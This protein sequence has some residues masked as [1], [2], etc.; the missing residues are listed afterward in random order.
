MLNQPIFAPILRAASQLSD[1]PFVGVLWRSVAW[2]TVC[3]AALHV[4]AVWAVH[5][6]LALPGPW[7]WLADL[8]GTVGA[9]LLAFWLFLPVA[10]AVG[11]LYLDR[12]AAAVE[13]RYYPWLPPG[14]AASLVEQ[15]WDGLAVALR[16]LAF[17]VLALA[18]AL[19]LPGIGLI[20][21][22]MIA[23]YAI[24]RGLFVAVAMRRM[25]RADA[26][27]LYRMCRGPVLLQGGILAFCS[28][29]PLL[30]LL[31]P[32]LGTAAMV[33]VLDSAMTALPRRQPDS[34]TASW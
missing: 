20:L 26:E 6:I 27:A 14:N 30:N 21:G 18:L 15:A 2:S 25:P 7:A 5:D 1:P 23:S 31:L 22:W 19:L 4:G 34:V 10:A 8:L 32:L 29:V 33:H 28:Y 13:R 9:S 3:F 16:V 11:T 17:N 24:G 12:I